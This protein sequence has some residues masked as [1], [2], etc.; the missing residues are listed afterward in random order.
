MEIKKKTATAYRRTQPSTLKKMK[1]KRGK[2]KTI[3]SNV[4]MEAGGSTG[5][6]S[7]IGGK[8]TMPV[9]T[10]HPAVRAGPLFE[11]IKMC[12]E[13]FVPGG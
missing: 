7:K 4:Y 11:L 9:N 5:A 12:K 2:P 10:L 13:D 3:I 8:S 1:E 6:L